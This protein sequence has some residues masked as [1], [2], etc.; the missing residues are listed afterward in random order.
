MRTFF[1]KRG[2]LIVPVIMFAIVLF[3]GM[4]LVANVQESNS[5]MIKRHES[6]AYAPDG[7]VLRTEEYRL[8]RPAEFSEVAEEYFYSEGYD[9]VADFDEFRNQFYLMNEDS[10][11][12][13]EPMRDG[14]PYTFPVYELE[15][16]AI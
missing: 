6:L 7:Y 15:D 10:I 5:W 3:G 9:A 14:Y 12:R 13:G 4:K 8:S 11:Q 2:T 16:D 1:S